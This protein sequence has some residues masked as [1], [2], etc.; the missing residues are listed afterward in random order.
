MGNSNDGNSLGDF[1]ILTFLYGFFIYRD[2]T[3]ALYVT[4]YATG[5]LL[6]ILM[7]II[8]IAGVIGT[9]LTM[10]YFHGWVLQFVP[11]TKGLSVI[12]WLYV[13]ASACISVSELSGYVSRN[14]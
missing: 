8:P 10:S 13:I 1:A 4:L 12:Y 6:T 5:G 9:L 11:A 7:G 3:S 14:R 2:P